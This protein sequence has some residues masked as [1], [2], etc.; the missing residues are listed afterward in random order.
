MSTTMKQQPF[1]PV[2]YNSFSN[3]FHNNHLHRSSTVSCEN[4]KLSTSNNNTESSSTSS[5]VSPSISVRTGGGPKSPEDRRRCAVCSDVA[6]GYH[7]GVW[8]CEGCKA[9]FKRSIQGTNEYI[10]PATNTCTID[11]H[12][13]K[14][15]QACRLRRCYEVGMTKGTTRREGKYRRKAVSVCKITSTSSAAANNGNANNQDYGFSVSTNNT[16]PTTETTSGS[17]PIQNSNV[18]TSS[19][20]QINKTAADLT[21]IPIPTAE[22][23]SILS[24]VSRLNLLAKVDNSRPLDD[25]YFLQLLAKVFDQ[26]LVVLINWAKSMPGYTESLTLDQQVT[27]IEQSWLDTLILDIIERS[28]EHNDDS[29]HFAPD[30][31][32]SR[33]HDLS[34][35]VLS[36][37]CTNLFNILHV[38]KDPHTIHEEFI[39]LKA[40]MLINSIPANITSTKA[41]RLL[42]NQIYQALQYTCDSNLS[43]YHD[44]YI[45]HTTLLLQIPHIKMLSSKLIKLFLHMRTNDLLPQ[46]DLLLEMLDAQDTMD[47]SFNMNVNNLSSNTENCTQ[48][49]LISNNISSTSFEID[50]SSMYS[51][52]YSNM[53]PINIDKNNLSEKNSPTTP[54]LPFYKQIPNKCTTAE[55]L[56]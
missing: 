35:P 51:D 31:R 41:F 43:V 38:F 24:Q 55:H 21:R 15:C 10:C 40:T 32:I 27:I 19:Q 44:N 8:S 34:S 16:R 42:T 5:L 11:K 39:S 13:R 2:S 1:S 12:R 50:D 14:S 30:F 56:F 22:F 23:L 52:Q 7:Y 54:V 33:N 26:E 25:Q 36:S 3:D 49:S 6:S 9:F 48:N 37:I 28:L 4:E 45:R 20:S 53:L 29:L 17:Q 47:I 46:A 18:L